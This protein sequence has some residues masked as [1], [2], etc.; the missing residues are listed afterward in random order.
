MPMNVSLGRSSV[1]PLLKARFS[2]FEFMSTKVTPREEFLGRLGAYCPLLVFPPM[3]LCV[4]GAAEPCDGGAVATGCGMGGWEED[5]VDGSMAVSGHAG[6]SSMS[7]AGWA[8]GGGCVWVE[9][10]ASRW[11]GALRGVVA[12]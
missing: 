4:A 3:R 9:A 7:G 1:A 5:A 11:V 12:A 8:A 2:Y 6:S 10:G